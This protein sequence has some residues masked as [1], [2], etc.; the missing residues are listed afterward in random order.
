VSELLASSRLDFAALTPVD[1]DA[2]DLARRALERAGLPETKLVLTTENAKLRADPTLLSRALANL[3]VNAKRH[4][5]GV[6]RLEVKA[7]GERLQFAVED[8][9]PGI[10]E[11]DERRIFETFFQRPGASVEEKGALGLGLALVK[12]IAEAHGGVVFAGNRPSGGARIGFELPR[13]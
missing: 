13:A 6:E 9:G 12:R 11:G 3:L 7:V 8:A 4:G 2:A 10:A 1:L 5:G